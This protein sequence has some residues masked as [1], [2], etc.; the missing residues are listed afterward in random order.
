MTP[1]AAQELIALQ[2]AAR[3]EFVQGGGRAPAAERLQMGL[4]RHR[5]AILA[6]VRSHATPEP[7]GVMPALQRPRR[8]IPA[9][10]PSKA[11]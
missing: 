5:E 10:N 3:D 7:P 11:S 4:W 6:L 8:P 1:A 9:Q 2:N